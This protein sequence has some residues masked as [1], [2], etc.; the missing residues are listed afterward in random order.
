VP[1]LE[2]PYEEKELHLLL[3]VQLSSEKPLVPK[4]FVVKLRRGKYP[5][6][7]SFCVTGWT[8]LWRKKNSQ[9]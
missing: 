5:D 2:D 7:D 8:L 1:A 9:V 3:K 4:L 6:S